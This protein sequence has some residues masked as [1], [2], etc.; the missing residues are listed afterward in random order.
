L[1]CDECSAAAAKGNGLPGRHTLL[2]RL[3]L[4]CNSLA[5][6]LPTISDREI[7]PTVSTPHAHSRCIGLPL[8]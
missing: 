3:L 6:V 4:Q 5:G 2:R 8:G 7:V 1:L